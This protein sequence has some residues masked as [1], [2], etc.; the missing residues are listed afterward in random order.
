MIPETKRPKELY[1][2]STITNKKPIEN[3]EPCEVQS[4]VLQ[5]ENKAS[6]KTC[7]STFP[8]PLGETRE[9]CHPQ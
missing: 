1:I 6:K 3:N 8:D 2:C 4:L 5:L 9:S 7:Q